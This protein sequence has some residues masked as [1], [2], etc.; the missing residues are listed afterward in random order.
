MRVMDVR[1]LRDS[2]VKWMCGF[3]V[4]LREMYDGFCVKFVGAVREPPL[5]TGDM[6]EPKC[7]EN[8]DRSD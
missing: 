2:C 7:R 6:E 4:G 5:W 8:A 1:F 3:C